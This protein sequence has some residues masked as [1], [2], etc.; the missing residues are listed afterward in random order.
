MHLEETNFWL[1]GANKEMHNLDTT[2]WQEWERRSLEDVDFN[3]ELMQDHQYVTHICAT[4][5]RALRAS[6]MHWVVDVIFLFL[7][8][9]QG[10]NY[11]S[12][13]L[14][15]SGL[16]NPACE[17]SDVVPSILLQD[18]G[19]S[20]SLK[21]VRIETAIATLEARDEA[22]PSPDNAKKKSGS[23][24]PIKKK[25]VATESLTTME[26]SSKQLI[27]LIE[28]VGDYMATRSDVAQTQAGS[29][30]AFCLISI[31][32]AISDG[33]TLTLPPSMRDKKVNGLDTLK[34]V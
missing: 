31:T 5:F 29:I 10:V 14:L 34:N 6:Y 30:K 28:T 17:W 25:A 7:K 1:K 16:P 2:V 13:R 19:E 24:K 32:G 15:R 27:R 20:E 23:A 22:E 9:R 21:R 4:I 3:H 11:G 18:M 33:V 12:C 8:F 26:A